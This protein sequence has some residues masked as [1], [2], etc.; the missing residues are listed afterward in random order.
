MK[1][2]HDVGA[3][4]GET[5]RAVRDPKLAFGRI[6]CFEPARSCWE[7]LEGV[8]DDR[9]VVCRY[10]LWNRTCEHPLY[11]PGSIGGSLFE[12]KFSQGPV[13]STAELCQLVR[14]TEW[15]RE[16]LD[17]RDDIFMKLNCEGA[18]CDI[19]E[20]LLDSGELARVRSVVIDFDV[21]KIPSLSHRERELRGRLASVGLRNYVLAS[22]VMIGVTHRN[23]IQHWLK[24]AGA[25]E[26]SRAAR[27]RQVGYLLAEAAQGRGEPLRE[28]L[29]R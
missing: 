26:A 13:R 4:H 3:H 10:G 7:A 21:R 12:D 11:E 16:N 25:E 28:V 2:F 14:A 18:E 24:T 9:V 15:F 1:V 27:V 23:R 29:R 19:L 17:G 20:D 6:Y 22:D 8:V 5:L